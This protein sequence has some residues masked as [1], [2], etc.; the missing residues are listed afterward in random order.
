MRKFSKIVASGLL[1]TTLAT[2]AA[3]FGGGGGDSSGGNIVADKYKI[4]IACQ[5]EMGEQAVLE[6]LIEAYE[7]KHTDVDVELST[8]SGEGF[9]QYM[10]RIAQKNDLSPNIIWTADT[11]HSQWD[12]YFIDLRPYYE[13]SSETDYSLYYESMLDAA[14]TNGTFKPTKNYKNPLGAFD[15]ELDANSDGKE[16]YKSQSEF[17]LYYAP[18]DYNKPAILCNTALF[19]KLDTDYEAKC[20][21]KSVALPA[22]YKTTSARLQE[23][24][25][26]KD[27]DAM[28]DLYAFAQMIAE[29]IDFIVNSASSQSDTVSRTWKQK[30][31]IRLFL[32][33]EPTY[34]TVMT[35]LGLDI[36]N[37]DG[38]LNLTANQAALETLHNKIFPAEG[39]AKNYVLSNDGDTSFVKENVLMNVCSRPV[40]L[41]YNST[42]QAIH[43]EACL[44]TIAIPAKDVAAGNSG[45][46]ISRVYD[47]KGITVNGVTKSYNDL[48]WDFIKFI[49]TE[50]GQEVAGK[51]GLNIPVLKSLRDNGEWKKVEALGSMHHEAWIAGGEL[52]QDTYN[53]FNARSRLGF[54]NSVR[55]FFAAFQKVNYGD[56]EKGLAGLIESTNKNYNA[57]NP[58]KNLR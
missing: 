25:A 46:A 24:L 26:G 37:D 50:E 14:S 49:I 41:G 16:H 32:E 30:K 5:T 47:G 56:D 18:R 21:E 58:G 31:A 34:T 28:E 54:R 51:T 33:W 35:D 11:Y 4:T 27:W 53:I 48:S 43:K 40:V 9:E 29:R 20:K 3:C 22:N 38:T 13:A 45:Y 39:T 10:N 42:L 7:A 17:G 2:S 55:D 1:L 44:E 12:Q 57:N 52:R 15:H 23:I 8:F 19:K 6:K 36:I